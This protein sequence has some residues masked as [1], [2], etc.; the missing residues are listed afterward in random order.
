MFIPIPCRQTKAC[1]PLA[2]I[3]IAKTL[4]HRA[5]VRLAGKTIKIIIEVVASLNLQATNLFIGKVFRYFVASFTHNWKCHEIPD[6]N[7]GLRED[8]HR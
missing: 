1:K 6:L 2:G 5:A 7:T 8:Y 4:I 3:F